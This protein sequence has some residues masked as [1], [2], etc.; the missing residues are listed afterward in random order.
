MQLPVGHGG[1]QGKRDMGGSA[2]RGPWT[3]L[4]L[5]V[6]VL[7]LVSLP[8]GASSVTYTPRSADP[9][10]PK[11][12]VVRFAGGKKANKITILN[13]GAGVAGCLGFGP[14][15]CGSTAL[16]QLSVFDSAANIHPSGG[17]TSTIARQALCPTPDILIVDL[18]GGDDYLAL[19]GDAA[20]CVSVDSDCGSGFR[21]AAINGGFGNDSLRTLNLQ[22]D[23]VTCG[24]GIDTVLADKIDIV[25][26]DCENVSRI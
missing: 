24:E 14:G 20:V 4:A 21:T 7:S 19:A 17:C 15:S 5:L 9:T 11:E 13:I 1:D 3:L 8:A 23:T 26:P 18:Q 2:R 12:S 25:D 22:S 16:S 10:P 6:L